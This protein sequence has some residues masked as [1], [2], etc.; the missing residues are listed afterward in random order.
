MHEYAKTFIQYNIPNTI[1]NTTINI[2]D[3]IYTHHAHSMKG[4]SGY[5]K[6]HLLH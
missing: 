5:I 3:K 1:N 4:F 2:I 6:Q